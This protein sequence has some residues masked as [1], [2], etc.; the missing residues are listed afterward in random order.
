MVSTDPTLAA[1]TL[2]PDHPPAPGAGLY[3]LLPC[4]GTPFALAVE[5]DAS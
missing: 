3:Q 2:L 1:G 4:A 5:T